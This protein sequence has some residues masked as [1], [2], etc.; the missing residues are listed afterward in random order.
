LLIETL[1]YDVNAQDDGND[2]PIYRALVWFDPNKGGDI[3][4]LQYLSNQTNT[5]GKS[6]GSILHTA[7]GNINRLPLEI[8]KSLIETMGC[9]VNAQN[10]DKNTPIHLAFH[11]FNPHSVGDIAVLT[12]LLSQKGINGNIKDKYGSTLLHTAC[13]NINNL[14]IDI[15]QLL[16]ETLGCDVNVQ[17]NDRN[18]PLHQALRYFDPNNGGDINVWAYLI[19]QKN[20]NLNVKG[21]KGFNLLQLTCINN[22]PSYSRSARLNPQLD[23]ISCQIVEIIAERLVQQVLDETTR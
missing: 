16:V 6:G 13:D 7:C 19:N 4:V 5:K 18:T 10:N 22:L 12:Y 11:S 21:K 3:S 14:P 8:F 9:D 15:F 2:T 23:T 17:D 1:G 20:V